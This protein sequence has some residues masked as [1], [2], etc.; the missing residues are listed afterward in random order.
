MRNG[1]LMMLRDRAT[2]STARPDWRESILFAMRDAAND[3]RF[4]VR[5][6]KP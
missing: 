5:W 4:L 6:G 2:V 1:R 3:A